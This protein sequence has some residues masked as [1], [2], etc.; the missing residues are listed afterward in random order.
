MKAP[1]PLDLSNEIS[2]RQW[3]LRLGEMVALAGVSGLI[4]Q[5]VLL[6]A[7]EQAELPPGLYGPSASDLVHAL[8]GGHHAFTPPAGSETDYAEPAGSPFQPR[9]FSTEDFRLV[10]RLTEIILGNVDP[11]ALAQA[12]QWIDLSFYSADGVRKAAQNLDP[13][14]RA[15]AVAYFGEPTVRELETVDRAKVAREGIPAWNKEAVEKR[16]I[17]FLNLSAAQQDEFARAVWSDKSGS[18]ARKFLDAIRSEAI[19]GYYTSAQ[20]L[21]ELEY[22][23]NA[24]HPSC[25]GCD[26]A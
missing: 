18:P 22:K 5:S 24:Y 6:S 11:D 1:E 25:P 16:G 26:S 10:T 14:H 23:G 8:S 2:R 17:S 20:G 7:Q 21:K 9:F 15:L 3:L 13:L 12:T 4:P 19:R